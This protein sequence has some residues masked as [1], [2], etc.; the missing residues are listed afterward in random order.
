MIIAACSGTGKSTLVKQLLESHNALKLSVSNT[1]RA[2]REGE[3]D[4]VHYHF[5]TPERFQE[6]IDEGA[7]A[8]WAEY[9]GNRYGTSH[10]E[11]ERAQQE[12]YDLIFEVEIIGARALK[13]AYPHALACFVLPPS[14]PEVER[15]LRERQTETDESIQRRLARGR[16]E[17]QEVEVFDY[18][19]VN[20]ELSVAVSDLSALYRS[21][22]LTAQVQAA[23]LLRI[24]REAGAH[25]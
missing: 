3:L 18:F 12:G 4:G 20:D 7:F 13:L 10:A 11:I 24:Q 16:D 1:T 2:P 22:Q 5:T 8:E 9:A 25:P 17:L 6:M 21:S 23:L 15:R 19:V 14:W